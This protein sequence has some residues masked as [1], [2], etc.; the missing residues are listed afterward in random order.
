M[1]VIPSAVAALDVNRHVPCT[2]G[3]GLR[4]LSFLAEAATDQV[5]V[6]VG[7]DRVCVFGADCSELR[8]V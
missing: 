8:L 5:R 1:D 7:M 4:F 6:V 2:V 3:F